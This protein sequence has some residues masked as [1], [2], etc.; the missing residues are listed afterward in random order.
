M[1]KLL[2]GFLTFGLIFGT[3]AITKAADFG[4]HFGRDYNRDYGY[5]SY[6][7]YDNFDSWEDSQRDRINDAYRNNA[8]TQYEFNKLNR[9]LNQVDRFHDR[10][11]SK[12]WMSPQEQDRLNRMEARLNSDI[13]REIS[14]HED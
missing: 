12:G 9:E 11:M 13:D 10:E 3:A 8:I 4:I 5:R 14:E 7:S 1:K 6:N 2:I